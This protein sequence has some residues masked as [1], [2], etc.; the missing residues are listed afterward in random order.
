MKHGSPEFAAIAD[1]CTILRTQAGSDAHGTSITQG[2]DLLES[3]RITVPIPE[4]W[5]GRIRDLRQG[6]N[7]QQ[8]AIEVGAELEAKPLRL[9]DTSELPKVPDESRVDKWLYD[10]YEQVRASPDAW[11]QA[12]AQRNE[13]VGVHDFAPLLGGE[14]VGGPA[15]Q[16]R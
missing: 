15:D 8:E 9:V 1:R 6:K 11:S 3:G 12:S 4:P 7:T 13:V 5:L 10:A 14:F 2:V 16:P